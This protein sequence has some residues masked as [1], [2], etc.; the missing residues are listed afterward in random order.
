MPTSPA[1]CSRPRSELRGA[2][3]AAWDDA[4]RRH[5]ALWEGQLAIERL[6]ERVAHERGTKK[7]VSQ[8]V[9]VQIDALLQGAFVELPRPGERGCLA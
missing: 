7:S 5:G 6:L 2:T 8:S 4:A 3:A 9:L 1:V